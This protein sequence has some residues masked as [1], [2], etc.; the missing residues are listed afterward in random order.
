MVAINK[1]IVPITP[2]VFL[3][4]FLPNKPNIK[5]LANGNKG[6]NAIK[7]EFVMWDSWFHGI[8]LN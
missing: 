1:E 8:M 3:K 4:T 6:I 2:D 5:K 7:I